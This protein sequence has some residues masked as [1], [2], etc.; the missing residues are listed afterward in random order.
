MIARIL[1]LIVTMTFAISSAH[2]Q[3]LAANPF[4]GTWKLVASDKLLTDGTRVADWGAEPHGTAVFAADG[5][6][7]VRSSEMCA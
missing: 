3:T 7:M 6:F 4:V 2:A 5:H 1:S